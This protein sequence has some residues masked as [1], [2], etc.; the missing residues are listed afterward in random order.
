MLVF[1]GN[2][3]FLIKTRDNVIPI[4]EWGGGWGRQIWVEGR[5]ICDY[6]ILGLNVKAAEKAHAK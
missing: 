2:N 3:I 4:F 6:S 1:K 5:F